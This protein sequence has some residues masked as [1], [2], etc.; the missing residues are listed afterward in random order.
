MSQAQQLANLS[1]A[2]TAGALGGL[3]NRIINGDA[4]IAQ[5][6]VTNIAVGGIGSSGADRFYMYSAGSTASSAN[7]WSVTPGF[8]NACR[9]TAGAGNTAM[10][11]GQRIESSNIYD[12]AG[13]Q[14]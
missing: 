2:F 1:Q 6:G 8:S 13:Q 11:F 5:R 3:R 4:R 9:I 12:L 7:D 10:A 14:A